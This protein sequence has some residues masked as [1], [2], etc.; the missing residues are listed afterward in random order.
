M[1]QQ[2]TQEIRVVPFAC[3]KYILSNHCICHLYNSNELP[4]R[5][6]LEHL[7]GSTTGPRSFPSAVGKPLQ[8]CETMPMVQFKPMQCE[9]EELPDPVLQDLSTDQRYL[10]DRC[11]YAA[12][13]TCDEALLHRL[14]GKLVMSRW[15][16]LANRV[17]RLYVSTKEPSS[18]L[19]TITESSY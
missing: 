11:R 2:S 3:W 9:L 1:E 4:L 19:S 8:V 16:T 12:G 10:Y 18:C 17:L 6:L 5:H 7:D 13:R 14:P 15:L